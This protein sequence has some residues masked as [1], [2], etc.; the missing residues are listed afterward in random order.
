M[1]ISDWSSDVC[2]SDLTS[3]CDK[4]GRHLFPN[5]AKRIEGLHGPG[6]TNLMQSSELIRQLT[7]QPLVRDLSIE[8]APSVLALRYCILCRRGQRDPMPAL[9][10]RRGT[11][12]PAP[13]YPL[14]VEATGHAL[15]Q[16]LACP[17]PRTP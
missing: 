2:S 8:A 4:S 6:E 10:R 12:P 3:S 16:P 14:V 17:P 1:R 9:E 11:I 7:E 15:P 5:G 13:R